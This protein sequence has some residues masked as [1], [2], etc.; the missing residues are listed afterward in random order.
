MT[1]LQT[2]EKVRRCRRTNGVQY[3]V[4]LILAKSAEPSAIRA[5]DRLRGKRQKEKSKDET[6]TSTPAAIR[7]I[8]KRWSYFIRKVYEPKRL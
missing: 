5:R 1:N 7:G 4:R 8:K 6:E 3:P 2:K